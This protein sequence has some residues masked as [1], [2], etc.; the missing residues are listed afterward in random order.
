MYLIR[1]G[2]KLIAGARPLSPAGYVIANMS[3]MSGSSSIASKLLATAVVDA[4]ARAI[5]PH[6]VVAIDAIEEIRISLD[7][8]RDRAGLRLVKRSGLDDSKSDDQN[9]RREPQSDA[10]ARKSTALGPVDVKQ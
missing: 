9:K 10:L 5:L 7:E 2:S 3:L 6:E 8:G 1:A 4:L